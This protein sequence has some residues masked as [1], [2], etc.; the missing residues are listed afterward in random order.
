M[1]TQRYLLSFA[2][3][4]TVLV[5]TIFV[6]ACG[7]GSGS[8]SDSSPTALSCGDTTEPNDSKPV[9]T[10]IANRT[11]DNSEEDQTSSTASGVDDD[12]FFTYQGTDSPSIIDVVDP[13]LTIV[14]STDDLGFCLYATCL[15]GTTSLTCPGGT[16]SATD[17]DGSP[18]CCSNTTIQN[19]IDI[20][21]LSC[22]G[23]G[24]DDSSDILIEI[25]TPTDVCVDY[26]F[27][28]YF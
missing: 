10:A 23:A 28:T 27:S 11:E 8:D 5:L 26:T 25:N 24:G 19:S 16:T 2:R 9:A 18:G 1:D 17:E 7:G 6:A 4:T 15:S 21:S 14:S 3:G 20:N 22:V 12:D 13:N